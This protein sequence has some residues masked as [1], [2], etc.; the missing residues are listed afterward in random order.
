MDISDRILHETEGNRN[1]RFRASPTRTLPFLVE[2]INGSGS[3]TK[4][5]EM[6]ARVQRIDRTTTLSA[7]SSNLRRCDIDRLNCRFPFPVLFG[8][9]YFCLQPWLEVIMQGGSV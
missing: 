7:Q 6:S 3:R 2:F 1:F 5:P 9:R 4:S 8:G